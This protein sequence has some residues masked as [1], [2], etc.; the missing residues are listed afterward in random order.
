MAMAVSIKRSK[1]PFRTSDIVCRLV[2]S[3]T[4]W[5]VYVV[6]WQHASPVALFISHWWISLCVLG[7]HT[8]QRHVMQRSA[9]S[10][11]RA[12]MR[13]LHT[14]PPGTKVSMSA[15]ES[16]RHMI[17]RPTLRSP[18]LLELSLET[19]L[20]GDCDLL[21]DM[22]ALC[23]GSADSTTATQCLPSCVPA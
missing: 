2:I 13:L 10:M 14:S 12:S 15:P 17:V 4:P 5:R 7:L 23:C 1:G 16:A 19:A 9:A 11:R 6:G 20:R 18:R 21:A 3:F 8:H 22:I